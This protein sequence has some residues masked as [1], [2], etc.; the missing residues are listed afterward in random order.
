LY[1][2]INPLVAE[3]EAG[4]RQTVPERS[5][6][7]G[8]LHIPSDFVVD[9]WASAVESSSYPDFLLRHYLETSFVA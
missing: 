7:S 4:K 5:R 3:G 9:Q 6:T 2:A 1:E 8:F